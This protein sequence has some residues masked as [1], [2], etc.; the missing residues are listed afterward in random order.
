MPTVAYSHPHEFVEMKVNVKFNGD[1]KV[2]GLQYDWLFD[3]FF[4]AYAVEPADKDRDGVP[5]QKGLEDLIS[6]ILGNIK[7]IDYFTK[8]DEN[9]LVPKLANAKPLKVQMKGRQ[10]N[11][12]F[13]VPFEAP[14]D[15]SKKSFSYAIYDE[16]FYIAMNH[17]VDKSAVRLDGAPDGCKFEIVTPDPSE[18][19]KQFASSLD[20]SESGGSDL[21]YNF[22]E[23][24]IVKCH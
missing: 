15:I 14:L 11:L 18:E 2:T 17:S 7:P 6:H 1:G 13:F 5:E 24:V 8:F 10:L 3:E 23:W 9:R 4:S 16:E 22:A 20:K 12:S 19:V 21:G